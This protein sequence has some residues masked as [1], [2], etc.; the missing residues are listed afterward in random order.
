MVLNLPPNC[1][2]SSRSVIATTPKLWVVIERFVVLERWPGEL[3]E[4]KSMIIIVPPKKKGKLRC[5]V[6]P[7]SIC[8]SH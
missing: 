7:I 3:I 1:V 8:D 6:I 2:F 5:K 4:E